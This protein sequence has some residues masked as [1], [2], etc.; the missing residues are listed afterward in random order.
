MVSHHGAIQ[1]STAVQEV[2]EIPEQEPQQS[3]MA[4]F[5]YDPWDDDKIRQLFLLM[6]DESPKDVIAQQIDALIIA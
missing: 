3:T 4:D 2:Q 6:P 5:V 1:C